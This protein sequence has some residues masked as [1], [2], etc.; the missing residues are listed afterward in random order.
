MLKVV[1]TSFI[2]E[3]E[4]RYAALLRG[5]QRELIAAS[6]YSRVPNQTQSESLLLRV[7][8]RK[9]GS[10][11]NR[12]WSVPNLIIYVLDHEFSWDV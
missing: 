11:Q 1:Q 5:M 7:R 6:Q 4:Y 3:F 2:F 12:F 9:C 8:S 10:V